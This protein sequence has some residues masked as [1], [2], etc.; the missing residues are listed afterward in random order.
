MKLS[1]DVYYWIIHPI[2]ITIMLQ[3]K[4]KKLKQKMEEQQRLINTIRNEINYNE[5]IFFYEEN[6]DTN[7]VMK[8][9]E[10]LEIILREEKL[11]LL[12]IFIKY[13]ISKS[14]LK[15]IIYRMNI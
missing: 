8:T 1:K 13:A 9:L 5:D 3:E 15:K 12:D 2:K 4:M 7:I 14:R 10:S 11:I 6:V